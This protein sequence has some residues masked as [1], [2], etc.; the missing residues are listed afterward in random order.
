MPIF[1]ILFI[2]VV[3]AIAVLYCMK[4]SQDTL[5]KA[6]LK[7]FEHHYIAHRGLHSTGFDAPENTMAAFRRAIS[8]GFGIELDVRMT[9]DG[10]LAVIHDD[11]LSR[12]CGKNVSVAGTDYSEIKTYKIQNTKE[13]VPLLEDV[14]NE[15]AGRVP[16]I[17]EVKE[18]PLFNE[19]CR[20]VSTAIQNYNGDIAIQS[21]MPQIVEWFRLNDPDVLRGQLG[22]NMFDKKH[23]S[24][25]DIKIKLVVTLM[26]LNFKSQPD[27]IAYDFMEFD[28]ITMKIMRSIFGVETAGW[29]M[30]SQKCIDDLVGGKFDIAIFEGFVPK[31]KDNIL[32]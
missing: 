24:N 32:Y 23:N 26:L 8:H 27:F 1:L 10:K 25:D 5:R 21:F 15:V 13:S 14:L 19:V 31:E 30:T 11:N 29:T 4:P 17:I 20:A 22:M 28:G 18:T 2:L 9:K 16:L 12:V 3:A 6:R 7:N